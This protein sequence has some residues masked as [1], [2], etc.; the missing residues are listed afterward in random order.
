M[1]LFISLLVLEVRCRGISEVQS[2]KSYTISTIHIQRDGWYDTQGLAVYRDKFIESTS[3]EVQVV[4]KDG[5][6]EKSV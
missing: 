4:G 2:G 5:V 3:S 1:R 6:V